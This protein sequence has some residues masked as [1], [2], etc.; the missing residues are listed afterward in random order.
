MF[1]LVLSGYNFVRYTLPKCGFPPQDATSIVPQYQPKA[2]ILQILR[3]L[4]KVLLPAWVYLGCLSILTGQTPV[5]SWLYLSNWVGPYYAGGL[6]YW[7]LDI[8]VQTFLIIALVF[9]IPKCW[10]W[11]NNNPFLFFLGFFIVSYGVSCWCLYTWDT[12]QWFDRLP[13]LLLYLFALGGLASVARLY[14][15]KCV[16]I[17]A[18]VLVACHYFISPIGQDIRLMLVG[19]LA[20]I[21][22]PNIPLPKWGGIIINTLAKYSL[23]IYLSHFQ[24]KMIFENVLD[25]HSPWILSCIALVAGCLYGMVWKG[26]IE[27]R[28]HFPFLKRPLKL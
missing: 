9:S 16:V 25:I 5:L 15:Q 7:F 20:I 21:V 26:V 22:L 11:L 4:W 24:V 17:M 13:H 3:F 2:T 27:P 23:F 1:L 28:C 12:S 8:W 10:Q 18:V 14:W 19:T 6:S